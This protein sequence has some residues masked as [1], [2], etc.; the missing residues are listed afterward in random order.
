MTALVLEVP[1]SPDPQTFGITL[2][3]DDYQLRLLWCDPAQAWTLDI[4]DALGNPLAM[5]LPLITGADLLVQLAYLGIEG[6]LVV[7]TDFSPDAVPT[8]DNLGTSGRLY[9]ITGL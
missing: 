2:N 4:M 7:Q 9:F 1:L 3:G 5:G 8:A 6:K